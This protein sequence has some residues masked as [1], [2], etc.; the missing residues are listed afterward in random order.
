MK[1][2]K[3]CENY[4]LFTKKQKLKINKKKENSSSFIFL[5]YFDEI[6]RILRVVKNN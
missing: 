1:L 3:K 5:L 4:L 6:I 2:E